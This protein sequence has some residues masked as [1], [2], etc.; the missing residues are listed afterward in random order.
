MNIS[1]RKNDENTPSKGFPKLFTSILGN[2][3][4][5]F[6]AIEADEE[7][8]HMHDLSMRKKLSPMN[9]TQVLGSMSYIN[10]SLRAG[11][12]RVE[13]SLISGG[14]GIIEEINPLEPEEVKLAFTNTWN[15]IIGILLLL[16]PN[17]HTL[18]L[19]SCTLYL[20]TL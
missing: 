14:V 18:Y 9:L 4:D 19:T 13:T 2:S 15:L 1:V 3:H 5:S 10:W 7:E 16:H 17:K 20:A 8:E 12:I 6:E 11:Q